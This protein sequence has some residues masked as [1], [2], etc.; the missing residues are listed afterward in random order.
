MNVSKVSLK[1]VYNVRNVLKNSQKSEQPVAR[2]TDTAA[3]NYVAVL[4]TRKPDF[5]TRRA[6]ILDEFLFKIVTRRRLLAM[7]AKNA[8]VPVREVSFTGIDSPS[9][10]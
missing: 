1:I 6:H 5:N 9:F 7:P 10:R 2:C 3:L 8:L 4:M